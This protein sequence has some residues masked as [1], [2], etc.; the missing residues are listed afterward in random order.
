[1]YELVD[2]FGEDEV[3]GPPSADIQPV[4]S[5]PN[6]I[7]PFERQ[8]T[9]SRFADLTQSR[10]IEMRYDVAGLSTSPPLL[11]IPGATSDLRKDMSK[12]HVQPLSRDFRVLTCDLR[13]QGETLPMTLQNYVPLKTYVDDLVEL[14]DHVFGSD[15]TVHVVGWSVGSVIALA[16]ARLY[17]SRVEKLVVIQGG[18]WEPKEN[19]IGSLTPGGEEL[20]GSD[21]PWI[22]DLCSYSSLSVDER[23]DRMLQHA[24][25]RRKDP[26]F[27]Q[28]MSPTYKWVKQIYARSEKLTVMK[29]AEEL[30][31]GV[32]V[33]ET[34]VFAE[35]TAEV[36]SIQTPTLIIHGRHDGMH[37]V[38]RAE[39]LNERMPNAQL[40][41]V[42]EGHVSVVVSSAPTISNFL[43][44][45]HLD[46][47][48]IQKLAITDAVVTETTSIQTRSL[49]LSKM[50]ALAMQ[51]E[52]AAEFRRPEFQAKLRAIFADAPGDIFKQALARQKLCEEPQ[53]AVIKKYGF[54][55]TQAGCLESVK[56][57]ADFKDDP[58]VAANQAKLHSLLNPNVQDNQGGSVAAQPKH[59]DRRPNFAQ[60]SKEL[61]APANTGALHPP[62]LETH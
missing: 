57:I 43:R 41:I 61:Q 28:R 17:P 62:W 8:V 44:N 24:D 10:G 21:W 11:Y 50:R 52:M 23:C 60:R 51:D 25:V 19:H 16:L 12:G 14:V 55:A 22:K 36:E 56:A 13:N 1:M 26:I 38:K 53:L 59:C 30:G 40:V 31:M 18:Y 4:L 6:E 27:R 54:P 20:F 7:V 29:R 39:E 46:L 33:Q 9:E 34:A 37:P 42:D 48:H 2:A 15:T 32:L 58:D 5:V 35:G 3:T 47:V 49:K 45:S